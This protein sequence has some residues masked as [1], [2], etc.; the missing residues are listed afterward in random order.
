MKWEEIVKRYRNEWVL[1]EAKKVDED[2]NLIEGKVIFHSKDKSEVYDYLTKL[3]GKS[4]YI[5][6]TG[7]IP[8]D[9][10]VVLTCE[11]I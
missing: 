4:L 11:N 10:A 8:E 9:L 7:K 2:F 6:Y 3:K 1:V 5:E